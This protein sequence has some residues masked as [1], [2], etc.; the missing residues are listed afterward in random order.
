M[1]LFIK[2]LQT[3]FK[4]FIESAFIRAVIQMV[5]CFAEAWLGIFYLYQ[6]VR[7]EPFS[8]F[9]RYMKNLTRAWDMVGYLQ[10]EEKKLLD[11]HT[12]KYFKSLWDDQ[13]SFH[14]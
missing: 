10:D 4:L 5:H 1:A 8:H 9:P 7:M 12:H 14:W 2:V 13:T 11:T 6:Q 3:N